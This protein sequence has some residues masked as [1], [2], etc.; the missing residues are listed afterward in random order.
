MY[1]LVLFRWTKFNTTHKILYTPHKSPHWAKPLWMSL[2]CT[3]HVRHQREL[4]HVSAFISCT[5]WAW[6][7]G[8]DVQGVILHKSTR[9][10]PQI[11]LTETPVNRAHGVA[12]PL[13]ECACITRGRIPALDLQAKA[14]ASTIQWERLCLQS[15]QPLA[16][17]VKQTNNWSSWRKVN[18]ICKYTC[19]ALYTRY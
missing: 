15:A 5:V 16:G 2:L 6:P 19:S 9:R 11:S 13:V 17:F 4:W 14:I 1:P 3:R 18:F 12:M 7:G 10:H 8:S